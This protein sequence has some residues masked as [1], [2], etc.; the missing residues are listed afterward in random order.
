MVLHACLVSYSSTE[1]ASQLRKGLSEVA[2][3]VST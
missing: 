1:L 3:S 2:V